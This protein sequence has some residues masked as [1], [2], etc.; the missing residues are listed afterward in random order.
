[1]SLTSKSNWLFNII[2][3]CPCLF[4]QKL[5]LETVPRTFKKLDL[6]LRNNKDEKIAG[7]F[8]GKIL[9][10]PKFGQM[11]FEAIGGGDRPLFQIF[12]FFLLKRLPLISSFQNPLDFQI[13]R[14]G[15]KVITVNIMRG[16]EDWARNL[17]KSLYFW[18]SKMG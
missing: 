14:V 7:P 3:T 4:N 9:F 8:L 13:C 11:C 18:Y 15:S 12:S 6:K 5:I 17:P 10:L 2:C 16:I 1:M